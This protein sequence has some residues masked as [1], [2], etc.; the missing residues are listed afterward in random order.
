MSFS[1][2]D[3]NSVGFWESSSNR[4]VGLL[5]VCLV[6]KIPHQSLS[7][8]IRIRVI[9]SRLSKSLGLFASTRMLLGWSLNRF[10]FF[11]TL[12]IIH[13]G[14][15]HQPQVQVEKEWKAYWSRRLTMIQG[16][17]RGRPSTWQPTFR[18]AQPATTSQVRVLCARLRE[19]LCPRRSFWNKRRGLAKGGN[20]ERL[21]INREDMLRSIRQRV[22]VVSNVLLLGAV[23]VAWYYVLVAG[24]VLS[25]S[26]FPSLYFLPCDDVFA[27]MQYL[28]VLPYIHQPEY[29]FLFIL[30]SATEDI[31]IT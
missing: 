17:Q 20:V 16:K 3:V 2:N 22:T 9:T 5:L 13:V 6:C 30:W 12:F 4:V 7:T 18:R 11:T 10:A 29:I 15:V 27:Y 8:Q 24:K 28:T 14:E 19:W 21:L 31:K 1:I 25:C 23:L 26:T